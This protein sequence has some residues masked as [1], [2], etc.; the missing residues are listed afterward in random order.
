MSKA[1]LPLKFGQMDMTSRLRAYFGAALDT[2]NKM[3]MGAARH[4]VSN[5]VNVLLE[6]TRSNIASIPYNM[7]GPTKKYG[8]ALIEGAK[9]YMYRGEATGFVDI[10]GSRNTN[11]GTWMLRFF[12]GRGARRKT[13]GVIQGY[14]SLA[15]AAA[16]IGSDAAMIIAQSISKTIDDINR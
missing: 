1:V 3:I 4:G 2:D 5:A 8:V 12:A 10:L 13:R 16:S 14:Y 7:T 11:D 9:A 15:N 6:K